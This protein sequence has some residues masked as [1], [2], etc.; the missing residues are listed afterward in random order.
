MAG[1]TGRGRGR[2]GNGGNVEGLLKEEDER[3]QPCLLGH[4]S[5]TIR[6][7]T[8][9]IAVRHSLTL[10][11][12]GCAWLLYCRAF[13]FGL[14]KQAGPTPRFSLSLLHFPSF[15]H[16]FPSSY[17]IGS[18]SWPP[19][20]RPI[21]LDFSSLLFSVPHSL[22]L[23]LSSLPLLSLF[24]LSLTLSFLPLFKPPQFPSRAPGSFLFHIRH[25]KEQSTS[26]Q[27]PEEKE[28]LTKRTV[29]SA[30]GIQRLKAERPT[31]KQTLCDGQ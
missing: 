2:W 4:P 21:Q 1:T 24:P 5:F 17:L 13:P 19:K 9:A 3:R 22:F 25:E 12:V 6:S 29:A 15:P 10:R 16:A 18:S 23:S 30:R 26:N 8:F 31:T 14:S 11:E 7:S 28:R 27:Y 20:R